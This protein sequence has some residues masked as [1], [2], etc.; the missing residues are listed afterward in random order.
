MKIWVLVFEPYHENS[1]ILGVYH[2]EA[3]GLAAL[4]KEG[5]DNP[6]PSWDDSDTYE[7]QEWDTDTQTH[8]RT[9]VNHNPWK[10]VD[11]VPTKQG[12]RI[13]DSEYRRVGR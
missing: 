7:L 4:K 10:D 8:I 12:W 11:G 9:L 13:D 6:N 2:D 5:E 1:D 3:E